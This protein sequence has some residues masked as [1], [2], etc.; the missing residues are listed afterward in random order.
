MF[1]DF[2]LTRSVLSKQSVPSLNTSGVAQSPEIV[3]RRDDVL[4]FTA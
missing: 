2:G 3:S 1:S 4:F